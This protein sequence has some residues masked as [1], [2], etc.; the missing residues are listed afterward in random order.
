MQLVHL[1]TLQAYITIIQMEDFG[2][3]IVSWLNIMWLMLV[4]Q[5]IVQTKVLDLF[6]V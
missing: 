3:N 5:L 6:S 4:N 2:C 1:Y